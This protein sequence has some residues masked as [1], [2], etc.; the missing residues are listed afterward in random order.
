MTRDLGHVT[1]ILLPRPQAE[2]L[3]EAFHAGIKLYASCLGFVQHKPLAFSSKSLN[4]IIDSF[5]GALLHHLTSEIVFILALSTHEPPILVFSLWKGDFS[6]NGGEKSG[7]WA[8]MQHYLLF[9]FNHDKTFEAP[10]WEDFPE[11]SPYMKAL[12]VYGVSWWNWRLWKFACCDS[13]GGPRGI[14]CCGVV[15]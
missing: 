10:L 14:I 7:R 2:D 4:S 3:A 11:M 1:C 9:I 13:L 5:S 15:R 6:R 8:K 12:M